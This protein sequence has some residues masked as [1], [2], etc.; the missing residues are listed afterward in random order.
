MWKVRLNK[1]KQTEAV[2]GGTE[3]QVRFKAVKKKQS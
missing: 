1:L 3:G 2:Q